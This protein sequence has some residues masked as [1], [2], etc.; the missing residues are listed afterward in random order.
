[1]EYI[2]I[3]MLYYLESELQSPRPGRGGRGRSRG[4]GRG[5]GQRG[6]FIT[7]VAFMDES[8]DED[9]VY[10]HLFTIPHNIF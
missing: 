7:P 4:R 8:S 9:E 10:R 3:V 6:G 2:E 1:M 5:R